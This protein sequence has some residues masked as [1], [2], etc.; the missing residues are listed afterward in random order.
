MRARTRT[1][2]AAD[3]AARNERASP[4]KWMDEAGRRHQAPSKD[5]TPMPDP[6]VARLADLEIL[7]LD[8]TPTRLGDTWATQPV[9]LALVRQ[10][11]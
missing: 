2:L 9:V 7:A 10:F 6:T 1:P 11:G 8:G 4:A 3:H 5:P